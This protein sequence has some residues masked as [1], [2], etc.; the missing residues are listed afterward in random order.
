MY[1]SESFFSWLFT[2]LWYS[3]WTVSL[4]FLG[5]TCAFLGEVG[6]V[7]DGYKSP[8]MSLLSRS[9]FGLEELNLIKLSRLDL[10]S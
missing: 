10:F 1:L 4:N 7:L 6:T 8:P 2:F 3:R 9:S 5:V